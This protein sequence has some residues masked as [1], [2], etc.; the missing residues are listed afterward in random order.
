MSV[1]ELA[2]VL[3][4]IEACP[5]IEPGEILNWGYL[6]DRHK[7]IQGA[8]SLADAL[9][10]RDDGLRN[11]ANECELSRAGFN[12][13]CLEKDGFGWL[14]GGINTSKGVIAYG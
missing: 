12:V 9:L 4:D 7:L 10:T 11:Y 5:E 1:S 8:A 2:K 3:G 13:F 6:E 14:T